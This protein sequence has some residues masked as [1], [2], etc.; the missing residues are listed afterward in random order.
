MSGPAV[1]GVTIQT[2]V[3]ACV[4]RRYLVPPLQR[5]P[6]WTLKDDRRLL[7]SVLAGRPIGSIL[8]VERIIDQA[9]GESAVP[10]GER[11]GLDRGRA[12]GEEDEQERKDAVEPKAF[13]LDGQQRLIALMRGFQSARQRGR[14]AGV[15][16]SAPIWCLDLQRVVAAL[17]G[18]DAD[19][20]DVFA[21]VDKSLKSVDPKRRKE[22]PTVSQIAAAA[23]REAQSKSAKRRFLV[24]LGMLL[25]GEGD[26]EKGAG[27]ILRHMVEWYAAS[28]ATAQ[29]RELAELVERMLRRVREYR[30]PVS[31]IAECTDAE[32]AS[33]FEQLNTSGRDLKT[34]E[35]AG[36]SI[37]VRD[38]SLRNLLRELEQDAPGAMAGI[39]GDLL[40]QAAMCAGS[41]SGKMPDLGRRSILSDARDVEAVGRIARGAECVREAMPLA[42]EL[43]M[44]CGVRHFKASPTPVV[45]VALLAGLARHPDRKRV[46][47]LGTE[48]LIVRR[49]WWA[50]TLESAGRGWGKSWLRTL[51]KHW[52]PSPSASK[53]DKDGWDSRAWSMGTFAIDP[54]KERHGAKAK[55]L[56][57]M[58]R[59]LG[60]RDFLSFKVGL[61]D[62][63]DLDLHHIFPKD[64]LSR[65]GRLKEGDCFANLT[66]I[67]ADTNR[68]FIRA[69]GPRDYV[70]QLVHHLGVA[71]GR[72]HLTKVLAEH[73]IDIELLESEQFDE[74]LKRRCEWFAARMVDLDRSLMLD[75]V[76]ATESAG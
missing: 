50:Q 71:G 61:V 27:T 47:R 10:L 59:A 29:E 8:V 38:R 7:A 4:S 14:R 2:L 73:G 68:N 72:A 43:L 32:A 56:V 75:P 24:Q 76:G 54:R 63:E 28:E 22:A 52:E 12:G 1:S 5:P 37:F 58:M 55:A 64:W 31:R 25:E 70:A 6:V 39:D 26:F 16:E 42:A 15:M 48:R 11:I 74:F 45:S 53:G 67:G 9:D 60:L 36:A 46:A 21:A 17:A 44:E 40:L 30:I 41:Q 69:R 51:I 66:L 62:N 13:V 20:R 23:L 19:H 57:A 65:H 34:S 18:M 49:W 33:A 3:R 35:V